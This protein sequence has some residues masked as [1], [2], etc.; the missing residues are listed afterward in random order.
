MTAE[1]VC[2]EIIAREVVSPH[3]RQRC[4]DDVRYRTKWAKDAGIPYSVPGQKKEKAKAS[5][6]VC[7][8]LGEPLRDEKGKARTADVETLAP[9]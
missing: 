8:H 3:Q 1:Q 2:D 9:T 6:K 5:R 7:L 4:I